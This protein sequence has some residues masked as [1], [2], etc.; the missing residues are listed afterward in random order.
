DMPF[1][2]AKFAQWRCYWPF[3]SGMFTDLFVHRMTAMLAA[4]GLRFPGRVT[5]SGGIFLEYD[6]RH[7]PDCATVVADFYEG[8]QG[9]IAA[10][11]CSPESPNNQVIRGHQGSF[12]FGVGDA[13]TGYDFIAERPQVTH[14]SKI[15]SE[16]IEVGGIQDNNL[17]HFENFCD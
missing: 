11:M 17:A 8:V 16:R 15:V 3:G 1:D 5:G 2:R 10:S 7:V 9:F 6:T 13:F 14:N 4:T 12:N